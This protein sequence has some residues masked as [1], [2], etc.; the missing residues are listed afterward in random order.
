MCGKSC[1]T[2]RPLNLIAMKKLLITFYIFVT[3]LVLT[4]IFLINCDPQNNRFAFIMQLY[5]YPRNFKI[6]KIPEKYSGVFRKWHLNGCLMEE[7]YVVNGT[8]RGICKGYFSDGSL[9]FSENYDDNGKKNGEFK[10]YYDNGKIAEVINYSNE[11]LNGERIFYG[12][13]PPLYLLDDWIPTSS[14]NNYF[15]YKDGKQILSQKIESSND[16]G[17]KDYEEIKAVF[18]DIIKEKESVT[19]ML[20]EKREL[21]DKNKR[22]I[23]VNPK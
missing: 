5:L 15:I 1:G 18:F 21:I 12:K 20:N 4:F 16:I 9:K 13:I 23:P 11:V 22:R 19:K 6:I 2:S 10:Y 17:M 7:V 8:K 3:F 14:E